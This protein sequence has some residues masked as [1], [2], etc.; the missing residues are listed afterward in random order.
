MDEYTRA[1]VEAWKQA[2]WVIGAIVLI[3]SL[4]VIFIGKV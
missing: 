1:Y 2:G 3:I 4:C